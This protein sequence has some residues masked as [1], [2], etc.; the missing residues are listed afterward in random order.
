[1]HVIDSLFTIQLD[2]CRQHIKCDYRDIISQARQAIKA[3][4]V[5]YFTDGNGLAVSTWIRLYYLPVDCEIMDA[6][7]AL[8]EKNVVQSLVKS[9]FAEAILRIQK[10]TSPH[11]PP[12]TIVV[13]IVDIELFG[14]A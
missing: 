12:P 11:Q 3:V 1:M 14:V 5:P 8:C 13:C 9:L 10:R 7:Y 4:T 2:H 6:I